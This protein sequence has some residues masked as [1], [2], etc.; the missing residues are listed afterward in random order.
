[1]GRP[2]NKRFFGTGPGN[3]LK[4]RAK[5]GANAEGDGYIVKQRSSNRFKVTVG[6]NTGICTLVV[7]ANGTLAAN[8]MTITVLTDAGTTAQVSKLYNR[9]AIVNDQKVKWTFAA[10]LTDGADQVLD[11]A[12][13]NFYTITISEQPQDASVTSPDSAQFTV[14]YTV[15]P[16]GATATHVWEVSTDSGSTWT[17]TAETGFD[18]V[19]ANTDPLY[20]DGNQFRAVVS[21]ANANTVT[22]DVATLTIATV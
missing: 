2:V 9:T 11:E 6:S 10:S 22:S 7:K 16:A 8:E 14:D 15:A 3:Q 18:L 4:V 5:I 21:A 17:A 13:S 19:V 20:V 1:M 12:A